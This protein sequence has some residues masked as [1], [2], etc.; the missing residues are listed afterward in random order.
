MAVPNYSG[1]QM[2]N[3]E[4]RMDEESEKREIYKWAKIAKYTKSNFQFY[5]LWGRFMFRPNRYWILHAALF[6]LKNIINY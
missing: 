4:G 3:H 2:N 5:M 6:E 1:A